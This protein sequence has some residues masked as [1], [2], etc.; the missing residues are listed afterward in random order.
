[1]KKLVFATNNAHKLEEVRQILGS[2]V[3]VVS[4][5]DIRCTHDIPETALTLEGNALLKARFV[6]AH[7]GCDCFADDTGLEIKALNNEQGV[8]SARY[9]GEA[10][11]DAA[12][13]QKVLQ[14]LEEKRRGNSACAPKDL[15]SARFRTVVALI[16]DGQEHL[17][18]GIVEGKIIPEER[19]KGGFGYDSI[20][21]PDG[22]SETFAE[23]GAEVKNAISHRARAVEGLKKFLTL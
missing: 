16:L 21:V 17:F 19:G 13:R 20:F 3:E 6:N 8:Y 4:L 7:Y 15:Y 9:A 10:K 18:E 11:N 23:L 2:S 14:K 5:R 12:N 1:M 22:Y